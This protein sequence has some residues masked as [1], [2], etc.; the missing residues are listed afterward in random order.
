MPVTTSIPFRV[1][2]WY[3]PMVKE[4]SARRLG[5]EHRLLVDGSKVG[6]GH[7]NYP[8]HRVVRFGRHDLSLFRIGLY[9]RE[10]Q[11]AQPKNF[12]LD[13]FPIA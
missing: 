7:K 10:H 11:L 4:L 2:E 6:F 8:R 1:R 3:E 9:M 13:F 12:Q 5:Q